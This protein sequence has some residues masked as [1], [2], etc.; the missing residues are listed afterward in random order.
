[1]LLLFLWMRVLLFRPLLF[2]YDSHVYQ[3][4]DIFSKDKKHLYWYKRYVYL[5][6][7]RDEWKCLGWQS[8]NFWDG[9][10]EKDDK[11]MFPLLCVFEEEWDGSM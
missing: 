5:N 9:E 11:S 8:L 4:S 2:V 3:W 1:M 10:N 6:I 7:G